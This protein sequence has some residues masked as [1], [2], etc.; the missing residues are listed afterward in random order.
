MLLAGSVHD[1]DSFNEFMRI[2]QTEVNT[3]KSSEI[4]ALIRAG[5]V[6]DW[7]WWIYIVFYMIGSVLLLRS[8][9]LE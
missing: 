8:Q 7:F 4:Y 1:L 6:A 5:E 2:L 3:A 9:Y